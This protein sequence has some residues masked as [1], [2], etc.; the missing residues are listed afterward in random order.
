MYA[1]LCV[2]ATIEGRKFNHYSNQ[3]TMM[4]YKIEKKYTIIYIAQQWPI[5][6]I[7]NLKLGW[8]SCAEAPPN[9]I[10]SA[11]VLLN[12]RKTPK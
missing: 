8:N 9:V 11:K 5:L 1:F 6:N 3:R 7:D 2:T 12:L 10:T 4:K